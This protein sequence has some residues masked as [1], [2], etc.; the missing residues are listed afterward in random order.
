MDS[1]LRVAFLIGS[2]DSATV[3]SIARVCAIEGV[4]P[5][6]VLL[7]TGQPGGLGRLRNL[8]RN[9]R[10]EGYGYVWHRAVTMLKDRLDSWADRVIDHAEVD[11]L[12]DQAFPERSLQRIGER[13]GFPVV[14][15]APELRAGAATVAVRRG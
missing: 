6:V 2:D 5:A 14:E 1:Q 7:D 3:R 8:R 10:R 12:L 4:R 9:I 15:V 11:L 13:Y